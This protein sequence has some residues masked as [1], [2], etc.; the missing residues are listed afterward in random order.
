MAT[1]EQTETSTRERIIDAAERLFADQGFDLVSLR[2]ITNEAGANVAA[3]N[4]HFGSKENLIAAVVE[5]HALP[6]NQARISMLDEA[7]ARHVPDAVPVDEILRAFLQPFLDHLAKNEFNESLFCKFMGRM[8]GEQSCMPPSVLPLF[9]EMAGR[10]SAAIRKSVP[11]LSTEEALWRI[12]FSFGVVAQ[13]LMHGDALH[14]IS[15]GRSGR[16]SM[17]TLLDRVVRF[18][19]GGILAEPEGGRS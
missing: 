17:E 11:S 12:H 14:Q 9:Q 6:I 15:D 16:P 8:S 13:A 19:A 3:V 2:D 7:E 18:C 5:R 10:Y 4:Y 1:R